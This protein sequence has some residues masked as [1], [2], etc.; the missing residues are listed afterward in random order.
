M[1]DRDNALIRRRGDRIVIRY[2]TWELVVAGILTLLFAGGSIADGMSS[3]TGTGDLLDG[4]LFGILFLAIFWRSGLRY[5]EVNSQGIKVRNPIRTYRIEWNEIEKFGVGR[6]PLAL[7]RHGMVRTV[8]DQTIGLTAIPVGTDYDNSPGGRALKQLE[9][10]RR[11][12][13]AGRAFDDV[14]PPDPEQMPAPQRI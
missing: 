5:V 1:T 4:V 3:S 14:P 6:N 2:R 9:A 12:V 7:H 11:A 13:I 10:H 8:N